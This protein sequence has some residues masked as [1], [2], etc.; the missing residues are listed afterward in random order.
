MHLVWALS[1]L[2]VIPWSQAS[3]LPLNIN[4]RTDLPHHRL[5]KRQKQ[6]KQKTFYANI[7]RREIKEKNSLNLTFEEFQKSLNRTRS[8]RFRSLT[9]QT[10]KSFDGKL[11]SKKRD[12]A[13]RND[14]FFRIRENNKKVSNGGVNQ[15]STMIRTDDSWDISAYG[16]D[17][18][19]F[20]V[21]FRDQ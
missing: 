10:E 4:W 12:E 14:T 3:V 21:T 2:W 5:E 6:K 18:P 16:I 15:F 11:I 17:K 7:R 1:S 8:I 13:E 19:G 9:E 20:L